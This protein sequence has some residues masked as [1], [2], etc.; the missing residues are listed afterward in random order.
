MMK[1]KL[2]EAL[3]LQ[4]EWKVNDI[5]SGLDSTLDPLIAYLGQ[6]T[7]Q[8]LI[9]LGTVARHTAGLNTGFDPQVA[10]SDLLMLLHDSLSFAR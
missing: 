8:R 2:S 9:V 3:P 10:D 7:H 1:A 6:A 4:S 5:E